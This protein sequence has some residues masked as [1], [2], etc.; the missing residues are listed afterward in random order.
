ME[1]HVFITE[2]WRMDGGV[3]F[4]VVPKSIWQKLYPSDEQNLL[5]L[6]NR[7]LLVKTESRV[8]LV[9]TGFG[10]K[11]SE[12]YYQY[13]YIERQVPLKECLK[14]VGVDLMD[15][16]DVL[17]T[18]LHDDHCGGGTIRTADG[19]VVPL[20]PKATYW[21]SARQYECAIH[22]NEREKA[23]YFAENI[24]PLVTYGQLS[25]IREVEQPFEEIGMK[26]YFFDGHTMGLVVPMF[27]WKG[28]T[29]V[30]VSDFIPSAA[31]IH[32]VYVASVDVQPLVA[33]EEKKRFL[34]EAAEQR[35]ILIY[36][37]DALCEASEVE[38]TE[39]GFKAGVCQQIVDF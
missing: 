13:K 21:V 34:I 1:I 23:T 15:V 8:I 39:K 2:W 12:K 31:H 18:H 4:G 33:L 20:F 24:E 35:Y 22:P 37:H 32:P 27:Q 36:E 28:R 6:V 9:N 26:L 17:Y 7:L 10:N 29:F 14:D 25:T 38:R 5:P 3:A 19:K 30:Y 16:T 11:Q